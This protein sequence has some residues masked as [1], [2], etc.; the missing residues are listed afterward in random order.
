MFFEITISL[1]IQNILTDS[2]AYLPLFRINRAIL[3]KM[4]VLTASPSQQDHGRWLC[5]VVDQHEVIHKTTI[6]EGWLLRGRRKLQI[7]LYSVL[8][9]DYTQRALL[10]ASRA[11]P[12]GHQAQKRKL[13]WLNHG[14]VA[15]GNRV[16]RTRYV[17][18]DPDHRP[19][20]D[21]LDY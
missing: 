10:P 9:H 4:F 11:R 6:R 18:L 2:M 7:V 19:P 5:F 13:R 14:L 3:R 8:S 15:E 21:C 17:S 20:A 12:P 1:A 16:L